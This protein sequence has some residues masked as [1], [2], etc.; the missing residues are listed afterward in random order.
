[1]TIVD[2]LMTWLGQCPVLAD[3][4]INLDWLPADAREYS[5]DVVPCDEIISRYTTG[6]T[7][8]QFLFYIASRAFVGEDIRDAQDNYTFYESFS[9][10]VEQQNLDG[11]LP[12]LG[13]GRGARS[14][15]VTTSGY[16]MQVS[17][18]GRARY[19]IQLKMIYVQEV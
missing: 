11:N 5:L 7:K 14:V 6:A 3:G 17:D 8:R 19:Q 16:P 2:S 4:Q 12:D 1:M 10:W 13:E 15:R 9:Q 18:D